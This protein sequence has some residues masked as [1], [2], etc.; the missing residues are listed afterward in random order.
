MPTLCY[1]PFCDSGH[2][3]N[4]VKRRMFSVPKDEEM[5]KKWE[6]MIPRKD[7]LKPSHKVC[8]IHFQESDIIKGKI[9]IING[10]EDLFPLTWKLKPGALP[11]IFPGN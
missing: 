6:K 4:P 8:E 2:K 5:R 9:F 7:V 3:N 1:V 11:R 10:K